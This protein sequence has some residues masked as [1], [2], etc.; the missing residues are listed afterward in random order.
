[1]RLAILAPTAAAAFRNETAQGQGGAERQLVALGRA[2]AARGHTVDVI[3][4]REEGAPG[5][6]GGCRLWPIYPQRGVPF[7]KLL[8]P[9]GSAL[10]GFLRDRGSEVLLQRGAAE[11]TGLGWLTTRLLGIRFVYAV[12]SDS[13]LEAGN[14]LLPH[15]QDRVLY[16]V[17]LAGADQ[18][19]VQTLG[20]RRALQRAFGRDGTVVRS[21]PVG[22]IGNAA[23]AP[24]G[25][26]VLWGGNLRPV[27]RPEWLL[28]LAASL[29]R[30]Q[31]VVFGG[32]AR[33][34]EAYARSIQAA[35]R[36]LPNVDY[37]GALPP[38]ALP[39]VYRRCRLLL[40]TSAREGFPNTL[41]AA[42]QH[43]LD[44]VASVDPDDLLGERALGLTA[45]T[46]SG[47]RERLCES[48]SAGPEVLGRRRQ[49]AH[50]YLRTQ[51]SPPALTSAW[52]DIL[53]QIGKIRTG[54]HF[55]GTAG[56][57]GFEPLR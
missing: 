55:A 50:D 36:A 14:E 27:K 40:I 1:V 13:D 30:Q 22:D 32:E 46:L 44:V 3:I 33:G 18:L 57:R 20:Q 24:M 28:S 37:L 6:H 45:P 5:E 47:L 49:R 38:T 43:G 35:L 29:P 26:A 11:L 41:L 34:H 7:L 2:L 16:R 12:A 17:G 31:F 4:S 9:K 53:L 56:R 54:P 15:P 42:W 25:T 23:A 48:L 19:V 21:Y 39:A 51:H 10:L 52:E 8:H